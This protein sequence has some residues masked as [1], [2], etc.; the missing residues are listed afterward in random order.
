MRQRIVSGLHLGTLKP[1]DRLPSA[2]E[3]A[4]QFESDYRVVVAAYRELERD[5]L[6]HVRPRS[7]IYL[8]ATADQPLGALPHFADRMVDLLVEE[9]MLGLPAPEFPERARRC[10]ETV[11]LRAACVECN[12]DQIAALCAELQ[13]D[14]G[15]ESTGV[16]MMELESDDRLPLAVRR[17]DILV[18]THFH[19]LEVKRLARALGKPFVGVTLRAELRA[20]FLRLLGLGPLYFVG[21]DPRFAEKLALIFHDA[22]GAANL[23]VMIVGRDPVDEIPCSAPVLVMG[24]ARERLGDAPLAR[25]TFPAPQGFA[26]ETALQL[27]TFV[28]RANVAALMAQTAPA[29]EPQPA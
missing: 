1:G 27:L 21:T 5:G 16:D 28:V 20:E 29:Q 14:Y 24:S 26:R 9:L 8:S 15:I 23:R 12:A 17:A 4:A 6:V 2:R 10:L 19:A 25:R 7:G 3:L 18:T 22:E 13:T 11:R